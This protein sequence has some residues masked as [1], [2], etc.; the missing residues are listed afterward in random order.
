MK[1]LCRPLPWDWGYHPFT[2]WGNDSERALIPGFA[3]ADTGSCRTQDTTMVS[4]PEHGPA[5][6]HVS[7]PCSHQDSSAITQLDLIPDRGNCW[8][9]G[10]QYKP[11][12]WDQMHALL[13]SL[14]LLPTGCPGRAHSA[15]TGP[16]DAPQ[17]AL[18]SRPSPVRLPQLHP[19]SPSLTLHT[20]PTSPRPSIALG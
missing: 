11:S 14:L 10:L 18:P 2:R 9:Q 19:S 4:S 16:E 13:H 15:P 5:S 17:G 7:M 20:T 12:H 1:P 8:K 3:P 6:C